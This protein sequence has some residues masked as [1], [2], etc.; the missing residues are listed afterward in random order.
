MRRRASNEGYPNI[1]EDFTIAEKSPTRS[2]SWLK[3]TTSA[4]IFKTICI[5]LCISVDG[6]FTALDSVATF[7]LYLQLLPGKKYNQ[8]TQN[9]KSCIL[10][11]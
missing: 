7:F 2:F 4:V 6:S 11:L 9:N 3:A 5:N 8:D 10:A 1:R